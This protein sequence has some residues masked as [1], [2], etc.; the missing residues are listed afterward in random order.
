MKYLTLLLLTFSLNGFSQ[1]S[2]LHG[3]VYSSDTT[4]VV[5][6]TR[7]ILTSTTDTLY[8]KTDINGIYK[9]NAIQA[10]T[11]TLKAESPINGRRTITGLN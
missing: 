4:D 3:T 1:R 6:F 10:D 2:Q 5:P 11:F 7:I 9:F 8:T